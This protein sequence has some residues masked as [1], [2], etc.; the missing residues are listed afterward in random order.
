MNWAGGMGRVASEWRERVCEREREHGGEI[1]SMVERE[2][3]SKQSNTKQATVPWNYNNLS[4][5]QRHLDT[6]LICAWQQHFWRENPSWVSAWMSSYLSHSH[7]HCH[8]QGPVPPPSSGWGWRG[9]RTEHLTPLIHCPCTGPASTHLTGSACLFRMYAQEISTVIPIFSN[10]FKTPK[11]T[12]CTEEWT[13]GTCFKNILILKVEVNKLF[14]TR[15]D[16]KPDG[17]Q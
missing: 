17:L 13:F 9:C 8:H 4:M 3:E 11:Y 6:S 10:Q 1:E 16:S 12:H 7:A 2:R 5:C 15:Q 14:L